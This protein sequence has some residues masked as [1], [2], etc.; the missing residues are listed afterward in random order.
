[1]YGETS[2]FVAIARAGQLAAYR[3]RGGDAATKFERKSLDGKYNG[4]ISLKSA[5]NG[6]YVCVHGKDNSV[7]ANSEKGKGSRCEF[8]E[9]YYARS[10]SV[11]LEAFNGKYV[12]PVEPSMNLYATA[13][14]PCFYTVQNFPPPIFKPKD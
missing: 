13:K 6:K 2:E 1:M 5:S 3:S 4:K 9:R 14:K 8:I 10:P 11:Y 7:S 12:C